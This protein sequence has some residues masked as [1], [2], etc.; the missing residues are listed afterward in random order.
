MAVDGQLERILRL[1]PEGC[2]PRS[3]QR[4]EPATSFSGSGLWRVESG[5]GPLCLR[6]WPSEYPRDRLEFIQA[7][8]W[9][10]DQEGFG[11]IP[12]ALETQHHHGF[13]NHAGHLW[14]L[15]P[16][17]AG[18]PD[19]DPKISIPRLRAAMASLAEFHQASRSFPLPEIGPIASPGL[20][21]RRERLRE[22][23]SGGLEQ[24][25]AVAPNF[26]WP[27]LQEQA[28]RLFVLAAQA[29]PRLLQ[30]MELAV[31][32][33]VPLQPCIRDVWRAHVLFVGNEVSG[34][35]DFG[36][37]RPDNVATDVAR[38]LGS[39]AGDDPRAWQSGLEAYQ[40]VR[41][42]AREELRLTYV[43]D[44]ST[45]LLG[46]LQWLQWICLEQR[47][48]DRRQSVVRRVDELL[49]RL[50]VLAQEVS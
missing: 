18:E 44:R 5:L 50:E 41:P 45:V 38:L 9:H 11:L 8:L 21:Q 46:G 6:C 16:W 43:F 25:R 19:L 29:G 17:L 3:I 20:G 48:F 22:L 27:E 14:E 26:C 30:E 12:L 2:Q 24:L 34:L 28:S 32:L 36:A 39:L 35:V 49:A 13:V 4:W 31:P 23:L 40:A 15:T 42:L 47:T 33:A 10:V 1:Y 7:V 37:M